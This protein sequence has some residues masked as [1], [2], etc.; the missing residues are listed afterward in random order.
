MKTA[1]EQQAVTPAST[2]ASYDKTFPEDPILNV[3]TSLL[4]DAAY[5][6]LRHIRNVLAHRAAPGRQIYVAVGSSEPLPEEWKLLNVPLD[7]K[8]TVT[9]RAELA[10]L[11]TLLLNGA[12]AFVESRF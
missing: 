4:N 1:K 8:T 6:E 3:F 10:R 12:R 9:R 2:K 5:L 7:G 11:V